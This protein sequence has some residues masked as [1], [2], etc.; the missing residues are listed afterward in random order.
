MTPSQPPAVE[1]YVRSLSSRTGRT[2]RVVDHL[3]QLDASGEVADLSVTVW[4]EAVDLGSMAAQTPRGQAILETVTAVRDWA[5]ERGAS[6]EPFFHRRETHS[7]ITDETHTTLQLPSLLLVERV[8][9]E[10]VRVTPHDD[11]GTVWTVTDRLE[12]LSTDMEETPE[13]RP[14]RP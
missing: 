14:V 7:T 9:D 1:L 12:V 8:G 2:E 3:R 11:D 10:L 4:G 5:D 13:S 6:V